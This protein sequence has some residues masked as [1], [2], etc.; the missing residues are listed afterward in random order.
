LLP[1]FGEFEPTPRGDLVLTLLRAVGELSRDDLP[2]RPG[3][4]GWPTPT[5]GAQCLGQHRIPLALVTVSQEDV[6]RRD[7]VLQHWEDVFLP[8]H[9]WWLRDATTLAPATGTLEVALEGRGL[10][11]SAVKPAVAGSGMILRCYNATAERAAGA[12]R[13]GDAVKSAHRVRAD[14]KE[15]VALV[16]EN[17]GR[18][19]RFAAGPG[20]IVTILVT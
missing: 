18:T 16:L 6:A 17:R 15:S 14:E 5:P 19:V 4:A 10:V 3:H 7:V 11:L 8:L 13:F 12:W 20:E 9:G 2:T 1:G